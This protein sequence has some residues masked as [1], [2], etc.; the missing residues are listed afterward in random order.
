MKIYPDTYH[1]PII[2]FIMIIASCLWFICSMYTWP[3][4]RSVRI[5]LSR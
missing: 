4:V 2:P 5:W 1:E 3:V